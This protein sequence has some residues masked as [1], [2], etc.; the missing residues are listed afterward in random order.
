MATKQAITTQPT[1]EVPINKTSPSSM[2]ITT[3]FDDSASAWGPEM[4][5]WK[6]L[7]TDTGNSNCPPGLE[8]L[9]DLNCVYIVQYLEV[10]ELITGFETKNRYIIR[11]VQ[12]QNVL[13][14]MENSSI[15]CRL[16]CGQ[17]RRFSMH[18]YNAT[19]KEVLYCERPF[20][21]RMCCMLQEMDV[22]LSPET[23]ITTMMQKGSC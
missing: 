3:G 5:G 7:P 23:M 18:Y 15:C 16:C 11:D 21:N 12:G 10:V 4:G 20:R 8:G 13:F 22:F 6:P 19:R 1:K 2:P 14:A 17:F 9:L